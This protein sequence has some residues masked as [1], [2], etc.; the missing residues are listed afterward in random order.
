[1][2]KAIGLSTS[3]DVLKTVFTEFRT[4]M[5]LMVSRVLVGVSDNKKKNDN[6][7]DGSA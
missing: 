4:L 1:M 2:L 3:T 6:I 5:G 7:G